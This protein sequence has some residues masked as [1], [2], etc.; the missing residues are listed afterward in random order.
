[1]PRVDETTKERLVSIRGL[2]PDL[3]KL[4]PGCKFHP[5]CPFRI[6]RCLHDEPALEEVAPGQIARCWVL[7]K[8]VADPEAVAKK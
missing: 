8:N 7:M 3:S 5:R 1:M 6:D 4:P 2:P